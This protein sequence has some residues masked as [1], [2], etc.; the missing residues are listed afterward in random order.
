VAK[1][2]TEIIGIQAQTS[3]NG[4]LNGGHGNDVMVNNDSFTASGKG[5]DAAQ[6]YSRVVE[7]Y[8][9][10]FE[11]PEAR[12]RFLNNT[13]AKQADRQDRLQ[14]RFGRFR[15]LER[16]RIY[17]WALEARCYSAILEEMRSMA[18]FLPKDHRNLPQRVQAPFSARLS[19]LLHETRH[20][21]Y[22]AAVI[23]L[24]MTIASLYTLGEW[25]ARGVNVYLAK[26]YNMPAEAA[27]APSPTP[28]PF[29][30]IL[31]KSEKVW[32]SEKEGEYEKW[33]NSCRISTRYET[34]N[35]PRSYYTIPRRSELAGDQVSDKIVGIVYHTPENY[36]YDF[37]QSNS[38]A[39]QKGSRGLIEHIREHK[40]Y[41]YVINRIGEIY[42]IVRDDH[43]AYHAGES[44]WA[45]AKNTYV[46]LNESFLGVCF[47]SKYD[48]A[49]SLEQILTKAQIISGRLLTEVLRSKYAIDDANCTTHG[50][51]AVDPD[52][53]TIARHH[54]WVHFF[55]FEMM[56]LSNKYKVRP[57]NMTDYGFT[58]DED[59]LAKKLGHKLWEGASTAE[60][61]FNRQ[62]ELARVSPDDLRRK[63]RDRYIS[64]RNKT[65]GLH[66]DQGDV[67]NPRI[68]KKPYPA[69]E[70][71][72]SGADQSTSAAWKALIEK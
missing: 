70:T 15:I 44:L 4:R 71:T 12:L 20:A 23:L 46:L 31:S 1:L 19:L 21:F 57:P 45:D 25:S 16:T 68:D 51:V 5:A 36:M 67:N 59:I 53:M 62:A 47:E 27:P 34:G 65:L 42:R 8:A 24:L 49:T 11:H 48:G 35:R 26:K 33:S 52:K 41:N 38:K 13:L 17:N 61:E 7:R 40:K 29:N 50:L 55:P 43:A 3:S 63:L 14:R 54:D 22:G 66:A 32:L 9:M 37:V 58:Y 39:I 28:D 72:V 60:E 10:F 6:I 18:S 30:E 64:Q 56:G 2:K 69:G